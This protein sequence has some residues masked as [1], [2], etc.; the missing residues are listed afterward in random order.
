MCATRYSSKTSSWLTVAIH[1]SGCQSYSNSRETRAFLLLP[2]LCVTS[3]CPRLAQHFLTRLQALICLVN[4][5][6]DCIGAK[7]GPTGR[8]RRTQER[9]LTEI[10]EPFIEHNGDDHYIVNTHA[11][12]NAALLRKALPRHL[13]EPIPYVDPAKREQEH[14]KMAAALRS[15]QNQRRAKEAAARNEKKLAQGAPKPGEFGGP[16]T[17]R[18]YADE[19]QLDLRPNR[20]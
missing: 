20:P 5:Q 18:T 2:Q 13:T 19:L 9:T 17:A 14:H 7:C 15:V 11:L 12:H 10:E 6:H 1:T 8:K 3:R 16:H 4:V